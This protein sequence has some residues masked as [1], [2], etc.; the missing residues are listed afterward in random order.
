M[1]VGDTHLRKLLTIVGTLDPEIVFPSAEAIPHRPYIRR[2]LRGR[3]IRPALIGN[4]GTDMLD[5]STDIDVMETML[6]Q[7]GLI[8]SGIKGTQENS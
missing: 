7:D 3:P 4:D 5:L 2:D 8:D 6:K 1:H